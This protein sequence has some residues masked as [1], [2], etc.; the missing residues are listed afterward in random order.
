MGV[1]NLGFMDGANGPYNFS[2]SA[3]AELWLNDPSF[4]YDGGANGLPQNGYLGLTLQVDGSGPFTLDYYNQNYSHLPESVGFSDNPGTVTL[5]VPFSLCDPVIAVCGPPAIELALN[6]AE[7]AEPDALSQG[8]SFTVSSDYL[9]TVTVESANVYDVNG[10]LIQGATFDGLPTTVPE[11][12]SW[13]LLGTTLAG[14]GLAP[15]L[16]RRRT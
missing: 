14:L 1:T 13:L 11:P 9:D 6:V 12:G 16:R 7:N 8:L 10:N 2:A 15:R 5:N 4:V 3:Q